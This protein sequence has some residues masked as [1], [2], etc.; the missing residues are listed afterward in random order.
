MQGFFA[1]MNV[2]VK[3][4]NSLDPP[5]SVM[6]L[7]AVRMVRVSLITLLAASFCSRCRQ[8]VILETREMKALLR[9]TGGRRHDS[10]FHDR[11]EVV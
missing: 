11:I 3:K 7:V 1:L 8:F 9:W 2:A 5:V 6:E 4:L 10:F